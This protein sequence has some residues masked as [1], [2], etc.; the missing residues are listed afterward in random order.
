MPPALSNQRAVAD[1]FSALSIGQGWVAVNDDVSLSIYLH[2]GG[3]A[4]VEK[5]V[6]EARL[7]CVI[8]PEECVH[9]GAVRV[10]GFGFIITSG[11][12]GTVR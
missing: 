3:N 11:P 12:A 9:D 1:L 2:I 6:A 4:L 7:P 5:A 10:G 8:E